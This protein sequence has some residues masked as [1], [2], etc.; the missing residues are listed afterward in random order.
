MED[1]LRSEARKYSH[2]ENETIKLVSE[3]CNFICQDA[4]RVTNEY[5]Y[6][7]LYYLS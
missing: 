7:R 6:S 4:S 2:F 3:K 1:I 5:T